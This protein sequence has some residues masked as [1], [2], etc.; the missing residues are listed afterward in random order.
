MERPI[1]FFV[2]KRKTLTQI[3]AA[4]EQ[5]RSNK[6]Q[7][8]DVFTLLISFSKERFWSD[9]TSV[10][11]TVNNGNKQS[12]SSARINIGRA[13][14][15]FIFSCGQSTADW[16]F[17]CRSIRERENHIIISNLKFHLNVILA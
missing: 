7:L 2:S 10:A 13:V 1:N 15:N 3:G 8:L 12:F 17:A 16:A 4:E 11:A 9:A 5:V 14:T 6:I